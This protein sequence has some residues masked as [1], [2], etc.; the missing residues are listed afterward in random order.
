M[1]GRVSILRRSLE[2]TKT[3]VT[4]KIAQDRLQKLDALRGKG[5]DPFPARVDKP[6]PVA[7]CLADLDAKAGSTVVVAGRM[8][9]AAT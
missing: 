3:R 1:N 6:T 8:S 5:V 7:E 2:P 9:Q 4:D